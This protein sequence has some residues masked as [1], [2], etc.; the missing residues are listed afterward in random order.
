MQPSNSVLKEGA[1]IQRDVVYRADG[2]PEGG[3]KNV[4]EGTEERKGR[5]GRG[6]MEG[7]EWTGRKVKSERGGGEG[8]PSH[9]LPVPSE[10]CTE[11]S[12]KY[13]EKAPH[14]TA[15][16]IL[17]SNL[18]HS[19]HTALKQVRKQELTRNRCKSQCKM[20][21]Q[22]YLTTKCLPPQQP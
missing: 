5:G 10:D 2:E 13:T 17:L 11:P 15:M 8:R 12:T 20:K 9:S 3:K 6:G 16:P 14:V 19:R 18:A 1:T 22:L 7:K 4:G 21:N